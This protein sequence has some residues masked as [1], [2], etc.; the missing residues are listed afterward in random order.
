[1]SEGAPSGTTA[2]DREA[3]EKSRSRRRRRR[4]AIGVVVALVAAVGIGELTVGLVSR[5]IDATGW[6]CGRGWDR[7]AEDD[8]AD[9][10][11]IR[12]G[13]PEARE[14]DLDPADFTNLPPGLAEPSLT[15]AAFPADGDYDPLLYAM[16]GGVV[17]QSA[18]YYDQTWVAADSRTGEPLW[19]VETGSMGLSS[20]QGH[21]ALLAEREDGRT[22]VTTLDPRTGEKLSCA[23]LDGEVLDIDGI[24][25]QDLVIALDVTS[26]GRSDESGYSLVRLD[27]LAGET[28][29]ER[30]VN[31][32]PAS[33]ETEGELIAVSSDQV[34]A[35]TTRW[36][37][38]GGEDSVVIGIDASTG[39]EI[40]NHRPP[41]GQVATLGAMAL[42]DGGTGTLLLEIADQQ[43][44]DSQHGDY[45]LLDAYGQALWTTPASYGRDDTTAWVADGVAIV[46]EDFHPVGIDLATGE[47]LWEAEGSGLSDGIGMLP[48]GDGEVL[49][50]ADQQV[51]DE[52]G[53]KRFVTHVIDPAT[54]G[55]TVHEAPLRSFEVTD[56]YV[57]ASTGLTQ[58]V[59]PLARS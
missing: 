38:G 53:E 21:V 32:Y 28:R 19:G 34:G 33:V 47:R 39:D 10:H 58:L 4:V 22:D 55:L 27:P 17:L 42:P 18:G 24:G 25:A 1:M 6:T 59:I 50:I 41:S 26:T 36:P 12:W 2:R 43:A 31:A 40:W 48:T 30:P 29:W 46:L 9:M 15:T 23:R 7:I 14:Q 35:I 52:A 54:G 11:I 37:S 13:T 49:V 51:E 5:A 3:E 20:V 45:V 56:S 8:L 44:W 16:D 57:L